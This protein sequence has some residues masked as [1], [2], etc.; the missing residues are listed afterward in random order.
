M[1]ERHMG[2]RKAGLGQEGFP[3]YH[4]SSPLAKGS[5]MINRIL[6]TIP[7]LERRI[8][9]LEPATLEAFTREMD[10]TTAEL[11]HWQEAKSVAFLEGRLSE[12]EANTIYAA[13]GREF[14][15]SPANGGWG[16]ETTLAMKVAVTLVMGEILARSAR[17]A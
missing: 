1:L 13:L 12:G 9:A 17:A 5:D 14:G 16:A 6:A 10:V 8:T 4:L 15:S 11:F 7:E 2:C 3:A